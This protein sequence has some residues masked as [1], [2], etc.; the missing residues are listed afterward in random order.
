MKYIGLIIAIIIVVIFCFALASPAIM[1][2]QYNVPTI[3]LVLPSD[4]NPSQIISMS[5]SQTGLLITYQNP[6]T[7]DKR[8]ALYPNP[9]NNDRP[10]FMFTFT[11]EK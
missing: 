2:S 3:N 1:S 6:I 11:K 8:S 9:Q 7:Y 5:H 4:C 10:S